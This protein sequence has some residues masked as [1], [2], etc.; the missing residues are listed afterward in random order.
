MRQM[1]EFV[2]SL[3]HTVHSYSSLNTNGHLLSGEMFRISSDLK[4]KV[5]PAAQ[6]KDISSPLYVQTWVFLIVCYGTKLI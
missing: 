3:R 4:K 2:Y 6:R 1:F 5:R